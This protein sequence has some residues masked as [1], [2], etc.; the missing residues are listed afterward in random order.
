MSANLT[1]EVSAA[2]A[3]EPVTIFK[4]EGEVN[5]NSY[6]QLQ[7]RADQ[8]YAAGMRNLVLD[9]S[10]VPYVSSAGLRALHHIFMLLRAPTPEE[11]DAA[12]SKGLR[13]GTFKS[14]HL[15]LLNPSPAVREVL[16]V[17]GFDMYMQ[18]YDTLQEAL[19]AFA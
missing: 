2:Q 4:V 11:S 6:E 12:I 7:A 8:E 1:I 13:D 9:L 14:P 16:K 17:S 18:S 15:K 19:D 10:Q 5:T 3:R